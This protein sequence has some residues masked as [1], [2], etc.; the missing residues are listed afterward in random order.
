LKT[1]FH[2]LKKEFVSKNVADAN[3]FIDNVV[4]N[5]KVLEYCKGLIL[6]LTTEYDRRV[7]EYHSE[8]YNNIKEKGK[9]SITFLDDSFELFGFRTSISEMIS[10]NIKDIIQYANNC[11]DCLA[12]LVNSCLIYPPF[13]KDIVDFGFLYNSKRNR[14]SEF[15]TC[16]Y[17]EQAF[18]KI[19]A[20]SEFS[21]LR[22]SN[23]RI[24]HIMD[25]PTS[26]GFQLFGDESVALIKEFSKNNVKFSDV[27]INEKCN[28]ICVFISDCIDDI[29]AA[30]LKDLSTVNHEYRFNCVNVYGQIPKARDV[31]IE[32]IKYEDA[33]FIIAYLEIT[34]TDLS[35]IPNQIELIFASVRDDDS[36]EVFNYDYDILLLK[37]GDRYLGYAEAIEPVDQDF[38]SYRKYQVHLDNQRTFHDMIIKK[39]KM[40]LYPFASNQQFVIYEKDEPSMTNEKPLVDETHE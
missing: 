6:A 7:S 33:D 21:F 3:Q 12:Q 20:H 32:Q 27:K 4:Y 36:I 25:I 24:K 40:K 39:T 2:E 22:K 14:L 15:Q 31:K 8:I 23:N 26:I 28:E 34:E 16:S 11:L 38:L 35:K 29:C 18:S 17:T 5:Y 37:I 13:S 9:A 30:I 19:N 1:D 10:K